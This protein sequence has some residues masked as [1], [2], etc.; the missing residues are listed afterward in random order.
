MVQTRDW[1]GE[2]AR[3]LSPVLSDVTKAY[4]VV[5]CDPRQGGQ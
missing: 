1:K 3:C 2:I 4:E 5:S